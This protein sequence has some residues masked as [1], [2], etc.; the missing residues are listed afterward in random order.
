MSARALLTP[1]RV[2]L[3]AVIAIPYCI[4]LHFGTLRGRAAGMLAEE[5]NS[6]AGIARI[7]QAYSCAHDGAFPPLDVASR[8]FAFAPGSTA[9]GFRIGQEIKFPLE[10]DADAILAGPIGRHGA[11]TLEH[12]MARSGYFYLGYTIA[13]EAEGLALAD[14]MRRGEADGRD[15]HVPRGSGT[16]GGSVLY[17]LRRELYKTLAEAKAVEKE[18][19]KTHAQFPVIIQRPR[20]GYAWVIYAD[21]HGER[22]PYPGP[23]PLT[24]TFI[25]ALD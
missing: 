18:S 17:A 22:L 7:A 1:R 9:P 14:A 24:K 12:C 20:D 8:Q 19:P 25:E 11:L 4:L 10:R 15:L 13:S 3:F 16:L 21:M 6:I 2:A 23:F 5:G